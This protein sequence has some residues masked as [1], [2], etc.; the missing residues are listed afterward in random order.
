M[1]L[2]PV[3]F[4][5]RP[6]YA[7]GKPTLQFGL[8]AEEVAKVYPDLVGYGPDGEPQTVRY[9]L[10]NTMLLNEVQKQESQIKSQKQQLQ[11]QA[12]ELADLEA[13]LLRLEAKSTCRPQRRP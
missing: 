10:L 5:Y 2:R 11:M 1:Q 8:I 12:K 4:H 9:H 7:A 6:E 13:R 3:V